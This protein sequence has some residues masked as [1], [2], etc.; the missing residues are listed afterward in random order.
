M[1][2]MESNRY[3]NSEK[4][5][6]RNGWGNADRKNIAGDA[7][8]RSYERLQKQ[9]KTAILM[10]APPTKENT[11]KFVLIAEHLKTL[12]YSVPEIIAKDQK[13][14]FLLLEDLGENTYTKLINEGYDEG[15]LYELATDVLISM[16]KLS[17]QKVVPKC[18]NEFS[19]KRIINEV[20][21]IIDWYFPL[22]GIS[23]PSEEQ[24]NE[25]KKL[26]LDL[27]PLAWKVPTS[28]ILFDYHVDNLLL[29]PKKTGISACGLLDFQDAVH[30]PITYDLASLLEDARRNVDLQVA[31][32]MKDK[33]LKSFPKV[34]RESFNTS[35]SIMAAQRHTRVIGTF[36]RLKI[37]DKKP[38]YIQHIPRLWNYMEKCLTNPYLNKLSIWFK[39]NIPNNLR[40]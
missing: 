29:I 40:T 25:F 19:K 21:Q 13:E 37:R 11:Y 1:K 39:N 28:L 22:K 9:K 30:G 5:L 17:V 4:F 35:W 12:G 18:V 2:K 16:H 20:Q 33:Y 6:F 15:Y 32:K 23:P 36:S 31:E 7:S 10:N 8:F 26:W 38:E 34:D 14:G 3:N 24:Q 27:I